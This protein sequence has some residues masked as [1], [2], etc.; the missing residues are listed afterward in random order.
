MLEKL[1][2]SAGN[3]LGYKVIGNITKDDY[4]RLIADIQGLGQEGSSIGLLLD[5]EAFTGEAVKAWSAKL[6]FRRNYQNK[7][8]KLAI[9]GDKKWHEWLQHFADRLNYSRETEFFPTGEL[10]AA[11]EWL[12][13]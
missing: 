6:S 1:S 11:W 7:I 9:V 5:L 12:R 8:S 3:N 10:Q 2:Q 13:Q 4:A